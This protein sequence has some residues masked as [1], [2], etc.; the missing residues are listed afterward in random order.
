LHDSSAS[1]G[2]FGVVDTVKGELILDILGKD[3]LAALWEVDSVGSLST[4][5]V[6]DLNLSLV[7]GDNAIDWEMCMDHSHFVSESLSNTDHHVANQG[8][9][10]CDGTSLFVST[11]PH[12][13]SNV[14]T[15]FVFSNDVHNSDVDFVVGK[16]LGNCTSWSGNG[17]LSGLDGDLDYTKSRKSAGILKW[18]LPPSTTWTKSSLRIT[19]MLL[20]SSFI[21]K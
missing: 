20:I 13:D 10:C 7:L 5:E 17:N 6:L 12:L 21:N 19:L 8:F 16:V 9:E 18:H 1:K 14:K 2:K 3:D 4:E 11:I 15:F